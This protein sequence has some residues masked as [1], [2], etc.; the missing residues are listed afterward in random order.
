MDVRSGIMA[1][2]AVDTT[3]SI[4]INKVVDELSLSTQ[5]V[6]PEQIQ[7]NAFNNAPADEIVNKTV[8]Q[9]FEECVEHYGDRN[10][11]CF[12]SGSIT[13][14]EL[15]AKANQLANYLRKCGIGRNSLVAIYLERSV[16]LIISILAVVKAGGVYIPLNKDDPG[17]RIRIILQDINPVKIITSSELH[18]ELFNANALPHNSEKNIIRINRFFVD[19]IE[20]DDRNPT[21]INVPEDP[22]YVMYTSGSTGKPKGCMIP[23]CGV[24]RLVKNANIQINSMDNVAQIANAAF[25]A[26]TFE[27]WGALLHGASLRIIPQIILLSP[28]DLAQALRQNEISVL[29]LTTSLLNLVVKNCPYAFDNVKYLL[30]GGEKANP[31]IVKQL[32]KRKLK[33]NLSHLNII[34]AYGPTE[35]TTFATT[36]TINNIEDIQ[37]NVPIGKP[38]PN[39]TAYVFDENLQFVPEGVIGELYIGGKGVGLGYLNN[40]KQTALKFIDNPWKPGEKIFKTGD[41]VFWL[42]DTGLVYI[43]RMDTQIKINGFRVELGEI[44]ASLVKNRAVKQAV[45]LVQDDRDDRKELVAYITFHQKEKVDFAKFHRCMK[46][47][48]PYYM[49][50]SKTILVDYIPLTSSGKTDKI[51]LSKMGGKNILESNMY[52]IPTSKIEK[53][54]IEVWQQLLGITPINVKQNLFDIGAHSLMLTEACALLNSK[55]NAYISRTINIMDILTYPTIQQLSHYINEN[56]KS[57]TDDLESPVSRATHQ[58]R[59]LQARNAFHA[60]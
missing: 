21:Y 9:I 44:E 46:E 43:N 25:D 13:Y 53:V 59:L 27:V 34:N 11:A 15:N 32:L 8:S 57:S 24:V 51:A 55:L 16:E 54:L 3:G 40:P 23:H 37:K 31:E 20:M 33:N 52:N 17:H 47:N 48:I 56:R 29:L 7:K 26:M 41:L 5:P 39:T 50:P 58:R 30:F 10:A 14:S 19:K 6:Q 4:N 45:V 60:T 49:M 12:Q 28:V 36:F 2:Q 42:P 38:I 1:S 22:I 18:T 35:A